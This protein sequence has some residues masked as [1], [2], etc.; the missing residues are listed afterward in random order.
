MKKIILLLFAVALLCGCSQLSD[1]S[2]H[3]NAPTAVISPTPI[4]AP[5]IEST[6]MSTSDLYRFVQEEYPAEWSEDLYEGNKL[7]CIIDAEVDWRSG[8]YMRYVIERRPF[9][10]EEM[11]NILRLFSN[12]PELT[13]P[14]KKQKLN[15]NV[16]GTEATASWD[17]KS[18]GVGLTYGTGWIMQPERWVMQG[19]AY[20]GEPTGTTLDN[21]RITSD[22]AAAK[23]IE[24]L[25]EAGIEGFTLTYYEKS[26]LISGQLPITIYCEGWELWFIREYPQYIPYSLSKI[27]KNQLLSLPSIE[28]TAP[29]AQEFIKLFVTEDGC[30]SLTWY[31]PT[32]KVDEEYVRE[33]LLSF[34]Q[35]KEVIRDYLDRG[36]ENAPK[37]R[38]DA[39]WV[40][41]I[42]LTYA[43][44]EHPS[45]RNRAVLIP[46]WLAEYS[47][48]ARH[49]DGELP[50]LLC[51]N[52]VTGERIDPFYY[53]G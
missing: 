34:D 39:I 9:D 10:E 29:I 35:V 33:P 51:I 5:I 42:K 37:K 16:D 21:V 6:P 25:S 50:F 15:F 19:D 41:S 43:I 1:Y 27:Q 30:I 4:D 17:D 3:T 49:S 26:R 12:D 20:P 8:P 46:V 11:T 24:F 7:I 2:S 31:S 45:D 22:E 47:T 40:Y 28:K 52:A 23:S 53:A 36:I 14:A 32:V 44:T 13:V 18:F 48:E 38:E